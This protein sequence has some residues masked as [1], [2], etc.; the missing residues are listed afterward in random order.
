MALFEIGGID[1][2]VDDFK[3]VQRNYPKEIKKFMM[4]EGNK[5]KRLTIKRVENEVEPYTGNY[6][7]GIKRGK[8]YKY[9]GGIDSIRVYSGSSAFHGHLVEYGHKT[10]NGGMTKAY[11]IFKTSAD[12]FQNKYE[13]DCEKFVDDITKDLN[14]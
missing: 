2:L 10:Q 3:L 5:L 1:E 11:H 4:K 6:L 9:D 14:G 12:E 13:K 7:K 8:Y